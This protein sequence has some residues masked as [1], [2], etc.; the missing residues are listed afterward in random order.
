MTTIFDFACRECGRI[1]ECRF[2]LEML[3]RAHLFDLP[4]I[5]H[6]MLPKRWSQ[7]QLDW[8]QD[9]FMLPFPIIGIEDRASLILLMAQ[10]EGTVGTQQPWRFIEFLREKSDPRAFRE[11]VEDLNPNSPT[12]NNVGGLLIQWGTLQQESV[13]ETGYQLTGSLAGIYMIPDQTGDLLNLNQWRSSED[14]VTAA[15]RNANVALEEAMVLANRETF[16]LE[17]TPLAGLKKLAKRPEQ[18]KKANFRLRPLRSHERSIYTVLRPH[19]IRKV[20]RLDEDTHR[21]VRVHE[22]RG[23][24]RV[25]R[26][27]KFTKARGKKI[28]INATWVGVSEQTIGRKR[29]RVILDA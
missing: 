5:P 1:P 10:N 7:D 27:D 25:L 12:S 28:W 17:T 4:V 22:R 18:A 20:M 3:D 11:G 23:H 26:S 15:I 8:F 2:H 19:E 16:I 21:S 24:Q 29:Y 13:S 14:I 9:N 6:E